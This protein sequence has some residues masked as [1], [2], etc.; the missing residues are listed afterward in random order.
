MENELEFLGV[1][2][3]EDKLIDWHKNFDVI[4]DCDD[5][6][7]VSKKVYKHGED[8]GVFNNMK[9]R[10]VIIV[11][12]PDNG[13]TTTNEKTGEVVDAECYAAYIVPDVNCIHESKVESL[14]KCYGLDH[15][16]IDEARKCLSP[17]DFAQ[18]GYGVSLGEKIVEAQEQWNDNIL[19]G[20]ATAIETIDSL[21]GFYLDRYVNRLGMTG[22]NFLEMALS[23]KEIFDFVCR[24]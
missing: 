11:F 22:W 2:F 18:E 4:E 24:K 17:A 19:N 13:M 16:T 5:L 6:R 21:R 8:N 1:A 23:E 7:L 3:S 20:F 12:G 10:Y 9:Y 14:K 15:L